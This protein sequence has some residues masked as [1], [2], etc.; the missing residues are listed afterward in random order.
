MG[1]FRCCSGGTCYA[2]FGKQPPESVLPSG[3]AASDDPVVVNDDKLVLYGL[4]R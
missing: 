4:E 2:W 1:W 3:V